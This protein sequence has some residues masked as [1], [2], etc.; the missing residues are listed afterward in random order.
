VLSSCSVVRTLTMR[1][2]GPACAYCGRWISTSKVW[3]GYGCRCLQLEYLET[4]RLNR[5][6]WAEHHWDASCHD[7]HKAS[8]KN[9]VTS[10]PGYHGRIHKA[11]D[12]LW[13]NKPLIV[14]RLSLQR[15]PDDG[16]FYHAHIPEC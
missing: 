13:P 10:I 3:T 14:N 7:W 12:S 8:G 2:K 5:E 9:C 15:N 4:A 16:R 1:Y 11:H 6:A